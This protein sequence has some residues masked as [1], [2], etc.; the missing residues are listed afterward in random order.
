MESRR[1]KVLVVD[2]S[3]I[4]RKLLSD[5]LKGEPDIEVV[6]G[7][8]DPFIARDMIL[9]LE[10]DVITL[11][12]EMPRMDG[13]S[14]LRKLM[15]YRPMPVIIISSL[16]QSGSAATI[17][18]L[19]AG[20]VD[21]L[22]KP[23]G[24][25]SVGELAA[26]LKDR[27]RAVRGMAPA[28]L[29]RAAAATAG[30]AP[31]MALPS[32]RFDHPRRRHGVIAIGASTGGPQAIES[33]LAR[34]PAETPPI[35]IAQHMPAGFTKAF[36]ERLDRVS[37]I[38]V[39]ESA[40]REV[41]EPG[42]AYLAPGGHH[43]VVEAHGVRLMTRLHDGPQLHHQRPAV[44]ELFTSLARLRGVPIVAALL[45]GMGADGADGLL[46]LRAAGAETIA[47]DEH[48]CIVFGMPREAITRGAAMHVA[49]LL[50]M[51]AL[52]P[53]CFSRVASGPAVKAS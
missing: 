27:V 33:L 9:R 20:A 52:I 32:V 16:T 17:D 15:A 2:D 14:F 8:G 30:A 25:S 50:R 11:D 24:P 38:R 37:K 43:L 49:T 23:G 7:A 5:A 28:A 3:A 18:A 19:R 41:L 26:R 31:A 51:P 35:V 13:I 22:A 53:E 44:D 29:A 36:A 42:V 39:I 48:S 47:E 45:T 34:M 21:V 12:I 40:G 4:V 10:P 1:I 46:A 6:G